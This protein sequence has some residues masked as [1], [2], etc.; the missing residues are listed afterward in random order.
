[1]SGAKY[2]SI[3]DPSIF[4]EAV[5]ASDTVNFTGP[6]GAPSAPGGDVLSI[7]IWVG[8]AGNVVAVRDDDTT[9]IFTGAIAGVVL[10]IRCKRINSTS[11]TATDM[12]ALF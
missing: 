10:P 4:Y 1:M 2:L 11:T 5:T 6:A 8:V 7:G 9:V 3:M 12:V